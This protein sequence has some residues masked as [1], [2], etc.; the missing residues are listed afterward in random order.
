[1]DRD[2]FNRIWRRARE[3]GTGLSIAEDLAERA[4]RNRDVRDLRCP[5][6][7]LA[8]AGEMRRGAARQEPGSTARAIWV[9]DARLWLSRARQ[10][11]AAA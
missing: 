11:R 4:L 6:G 2:T 5:A 3:K 9:S 10:R 7:A 1:M 8:H